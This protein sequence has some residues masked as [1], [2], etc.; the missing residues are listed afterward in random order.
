MCIRDRVMSICRTFESALLKA[1]TSVEIK[2]DGLRIPF[3]SNLDNERLM[4][5]LAACD[6]ERIFCI[7]EALRRELIDVEGLYEMLRIDRW[8][9]NKIKGIVDLEKTLQSQPLTKELLYEAE[10]RG[11]TDSEIL[12]LSGVPREV[13]QD[14]RIYNDIFPVYKLSLIHI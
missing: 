4:E 5:K 1:L 9:L 3:V 2:C 14:I 10:S 11:F 8:F 12:K 6:D 7:A 13:L